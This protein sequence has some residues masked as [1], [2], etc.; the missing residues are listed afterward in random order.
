MHARK[1]LHGCVARIVSHKL[2]VDLENAFQF[3]IEH[4][5]IDVRQVEIDH[6]LAIDAQVVLVNHFKDRARSHIPRHQVA[7]LRIPL[8]QEVPALALRNRF[9]I[10]IV[11]LFLRDPDAPTLSAR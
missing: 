8:L 11:P 3:A 2:L 1:N 9:R 7:V 4:L 10:A 6:R 5:A